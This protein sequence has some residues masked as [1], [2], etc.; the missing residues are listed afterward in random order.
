MTEPQRIWWARPRKLCALERPGGGAQPPPRAPRRPRST[1]LTPAGRASGDLDDAHP[2][3]PRAL[4]RRRPRLA[5]RAG[6]V[7]GR[8]G[9]LAGGASA[10]C[11]GAS[12]GAAARWRV[13]GNRRTDF[14]ARVCAAHLHDARR[15]DPLESLAAAAA[16]GLD[17][18]PD[19]CALVG[20]S[21]PTSS[22]SCSAEDERRASR[23]RPRAADR[24][25]P[26]PPHPGRRSAPA[27]R[28]ARALRRR[29]HV[30]VH[31]VAHHERTA[32]AETVERRQQ[33]LRLAACPRS[34]ALRSLATSTAARM[35]PVPGHR[36]SGIG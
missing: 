30:G 7:D 6:R 3:Q 34:S 17:V 2:A 20:S 22:G 15:R 9:G 14:V 16:A 32:L 33:Q 31:A 19:A 23:P 8:G 13:H 25:R 12:C 21:S 1:Y 11:S 10:R 5:P 35:A 18:G 27:R 24:L 29:G 26:G 36:P 28:R 4:R